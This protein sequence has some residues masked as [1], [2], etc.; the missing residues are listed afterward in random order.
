MSIA[1]APAARR[2]CRHGLAGQIDS[3][4]NAHRLTARLWGG[5]GMKGRLLG[6]AAVLALTVAVSAGAHAQQTFPWS[7]TSLSPDRRAELVLGQ[8]TQDE[9]IALVNGDF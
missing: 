9:K 8:M 4:D 2:L 6:G 7:D 5:N 1:E 3:A